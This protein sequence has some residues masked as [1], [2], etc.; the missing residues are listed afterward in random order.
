MNNPALTLRQMVYLPKTCLLVGL[1]E[2]WWFN[3]GKT[4]ESKLT[5]GFAKPRQPW[6]SKENDLQMVGDPALD[7]IFPNICKSGV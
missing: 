6:S 4:E 5:K 3:G 7:E 2:T 1:Y